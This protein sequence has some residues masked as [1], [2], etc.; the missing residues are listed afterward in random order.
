MVIALSNLTLTQEL[1][2]MIFIEA[3]LDVSVSENRTHAKAAQKAIDIIFSVAQK[4]YGDKVKAASLPVF[5][6]LA[7]RFYACCFHK[8]WY[9]KAGGCLGISHLVSLMPI[10]WTRVHQ[11]PF[12]KGLVQ[13]LQDIPHAVSLSTLEDAS[14]TFAS[15]ITSCNARN[16]S[17]EQEDVLREVVSFLAS[18]LLNTTKAVRTAVQ[19]AL[20][21]LAEIT[22]D[23]VSELL[24]PFTEQYI[25]KPVFEFSLKTHPVG[26]Q[27][28]ILETLA[29]CLQL[30]PPLL[31]LSHELLELI[32][33]AIVLFDT[34]DDNQARVTNAPTVHMEGVTTSIPGAGAQLLSHLV[35]FKIAALEVFAAT[36]SS[37]SDEIVSL[38][39]A[40]NY[41]S[42]RLTLY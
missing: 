17:A 26:K 25:R 32:E 34:E 21:A 7:L 11:L 36:A 27:T 10:E 4:F 37:W 8:E 29:F 12:L 2:P 20:R 15:V 22:G 39:L 5:E 1:D 30:R 13:T 31:R 33:E 35:E 16:A 23:E 6:E 14:Q 9:F 38:Q 42:I 18:N 3:L 41:S 24:A 40:R 19:S 28:A